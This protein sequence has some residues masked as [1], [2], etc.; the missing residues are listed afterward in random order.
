MYRK[1]KYKK[2][3]ALYVEL[4]D[5][6]PKEPRWSRRVGD[7]HRR[8]GDT[9][10][11]VA[12][13][14][15]AAEVYMSAGFLIK[16]MAVCKLIL[17]IDPLHKRTRERMATISSQTSRTRTLTHSPFDP[18][19]SSDS[20]GRFDTQPKATLPNRATTNR[21]T[22]NRATT[23]RATTNSNPVDT[24]ATAGPSL[25]PNGTD[26]APEK[27]VSGSQRASTVE[28]EVDDLEDLHT[29]PEEI[30]EG[31]TAVEAPE[32]I[33]NMNLAG[34][35]GGARPYDNLSDDPG[36]VH[37]RRGDSGILEI[38]LDH[39]AFERLPEFE[40]P[41]FG[42]WADSDTV[43]SEISATAKAALREIPL[44]SA[45]SPQSLATVIRGAELLQLQAGETVF[46]E[47]DI[48]KELYV[49]SEGK[50]GVTVQ[51]EPTTSPGEMLGENQ[52]FGEFALMTDSP[53]NATVTALE[54]TELL[55]VKRETFTELMEGEPQVLS[56]VLGFLRD[57]LVD[58]LVR[59]SP[60][61]TRLPLSARK[62]F[63]EKFRFLEVETSA[64]LLLQGKSQ[65][66]LYVVLS[67]SFTMQHKDGH[68][69]HKVADLGPGDIIGE[70]AVLDD[71]T[72]QVTVTAHKKAHVLHLPESEVKTMMVSYPQ[73]SQVFRDV[74]EQRRALLQKH[75]S[76]GVEFEELSVDV[77]G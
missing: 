20:S 53:R 34:L 42:I 54:P 23:N 40:P 11:A 59:T 52:F 19:S 58:R 15:L 67:G 18:V 62:Q 48:G 8:L 35:V 61:F 39:V 72:S 37:E 68:H 26:G 24:V 65:Q 45:L 47:G 73:L 38:P 74:A 4:Q 13:Y 27:R 21:A 75:I 7:I 1:G 30:S 46:Q 49:I 5:R 57:R 32:A 69:T 2:A 63:A 60:L 25:S 33:E 44:F 14:S 36:A 28:L 10:E 76:G 17:Q 12:S 9:T 55:K 22:T 56:I 70:M 66:G 43:R 6:E 64:V 3:L 41:D 16:A 77:V 50:V 71:E 51:S 29:L 31:P